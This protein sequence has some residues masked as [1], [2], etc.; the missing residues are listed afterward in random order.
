MTIKRLSITILL[1]TI[2]TFSMWAQRVQVVSPRH[3][4]VG[5]EF[6]VQYIIN[7]QDVR[8]FRMGNLPHG[9]EKLCGPYTAQQS[10][11]QMV[12]GHVTSSSYISFS[13]VLKASKSGTFSIPPA[14]F[15][16]NGMNLASTPVK[17]TASGNTSYR[18]ASSAGATPYDEPEENYR[19]PQ[20]NGKDLFIR[21]IASKT[22]VHEQEPIMLTYK[23][24]TTTNLVQL[25]DVKM[26]DLT[27]FHVQEVKLPQQKTFHT[28]RLGNKTYKCVVWSQYMMYPQMTGKLQIPSIMFHGVVKEQNRDIDPF[29]AFFDGGGYKEV[30]RDISAN[31]VTIQVDPLPQKPA[32]F[33][34]GVGTFNI[35]AQLNKKTIKVGDPLNLRVVVG[36]SGNLKLIKHP[37]L[38]V[39]KGFDRYDAKV[40]DKTKLTANGVE[41]NVVYDFVVVPRKQGAYTIPSV[42]FTYYD[43]KS[44][45]YRTLR[46][47]SFQVQVEKGD[48]TNSSVSDYSDAQE[49]ILPIKTGKADSQTLHNFFFNSLP[50]WF[51]IILMIVAY[52]FALYRLRNKMAERAD[53]LG[54]QRKKASRAALERLHHADTYKLKGQTQQFYDE[55][56]Q[57]LWGYAS[58][59]MNLPLETLNRDTVKEQ[60][61]KNNIPDET[62]ERFIGIVDDCEFARYAPSE[63]QGNMTQI[64][65]NAMTII[66]KIETTL[67]NKPG[68]S[69]K[70]KS[71]FVFLFLL[72][73]SLFP[74]SSSAI[75]KQNADAEYQKGN[76]S[77]AV[78][79][80]KEILEGGVSS[81]V[82]YNLGNAYYRLDNIPQAILAYERALQLSPS[83]GDIR[84]NLQMAQSKT[85]D[86]ITPD[87]EMFFV[88][89]YKALVNLFGVDS[90][91]VIGLLC[92]LLS[93]VMSCVFFL[94]TTPVRRKW[95]FF[96]GL[97][98]LCIFIF[99]I[100][101]AHQQK[102]ELCQ[103][104]G[105]IIITPTVSVKKTPSESGTETFVIHEGTK[106]FVTDH[107]MRS[108]YNVKLEDGR[109]GWIKSNQLELI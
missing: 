49:D 103:K 14:R 86:K 99:S 57:A 51:V 18:S 48:G 79:D 8:D 30:K 20:T 68:C 64:I 54:M 28:E 94:S 11:Y 42:T 84:F 65:E 80:Y 5:E 36:G 74:L 9:V 67:Q 1:I 7:T 39:P 81:S 40:T 61:S 21:V 69:S 33:S 102:S 19:K 89:W 95:G 87:G 62:I 92:L 13:Y 101:F 46:T 50:Y 82:Y 109:E 97:F 105:A 73:I 44:N 104:N 66:S 52:A 22:R 100:V 26:P 56:L 63:A 96:A 76:Y 85:I 93:M 4:S 60:M 106:V 58:D 12:N 107:S 24:Y 70:K 37:V 75:T 53:V 29:E 38:N 23:V 59:S 25:Y 88:T 45:S 55:V 78:K 6:E 98:F 3:V 15:V 17:F 83:D 108:W 77:Q 35:S 41:G 16:A 34:G 32:D 27:G 72:A 31:G 2:L 43:V 71:A 91:A 10:S 47:Q 90:W